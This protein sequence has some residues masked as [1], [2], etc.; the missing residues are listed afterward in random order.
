MKSKDFAS[1]ASWIGCAGVE[2][3]ATS[4]VGEDVTGLDWM[5]VL[6]PTFIGAT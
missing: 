2:D 4:L 6:E 5:S 1:R 3:V